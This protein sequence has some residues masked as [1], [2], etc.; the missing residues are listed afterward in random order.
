MKPVKLIL[1]VLLLIFSAEGCK[2]DKREWLLP[3]KP[4]H[5]L[6]AK[7]FE[8]LT[9]EITYVDGHQPTEVALT[10]LKNFLNDRLNKPGGI[11]YVYKSI[12]S[13]GKSA[14]SIEDLRQIEK[15]HRA[16]YSKHKN[17][18][19]FVFF[20]D[21]QYSDGNVLGIAYGNSS[22]GVFEK[23]IDDHSGGIGQPQ[24]NILETT[25][26]EHEFGHLMGLVDNGTDMVTAHNADGKHCNNE[27]CLMYYAVETSD[28]MANI[29]GGSVPDLD[30]NCL[31]DLRKNGGK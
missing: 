13:P 11:N 24:K 14:Y 8:S 21:A 28:I 25:V 3:I 16:S 20:A 22:V 19:A 7:K 1:A 18:V 17:L 9:I 6:S 27:N 12:S 5:F 31:A 30:N 10:N 26:L 23:S 15:D 2:K 29:I 4:E